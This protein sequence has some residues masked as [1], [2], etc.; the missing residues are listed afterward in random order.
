M[1]TRRSAFKAAAGIAAATA[2]G[3]PHGALAADKV[4]DVG[5]D[6]SFTGADAES[7]QRVAN[8]AIMAFDDANKNHEVPGYTFNLIKFDDGTATAG[9]YDP[10]QAATNARKMVSD[11]NMVAAVG[12]QMSGAGKAMAPILSAGDLA[13]ITPSSTNPDITDPKFAAQ[14]RPA[15]KPIYFRTVAT[16]AY[17][18][19]NMANYM[20]ETLHVKTVYILDDSGAYGVGLADAFQAQATKI[21]L[22]VLGRDRLDPKAADYSAVLTKIKSLNPDALYFGGV[23]QAGVKLAKQSYDIIPKVIK[24]GGDGMQSADLLSGAGFPAVEGWYATIAAPHVS[25]DPQLAD[26]S[27]RYFARFKMQPDDYTITNYDGA[28]AIINAVKAVIKAGKPV[29]RSNVRDAL[30]NV[31]FTSLQGPIAFDANGDLKNKVISVFQ[32]RKDASKP[33]N[34]PNAQYKYIGVAPQ[35]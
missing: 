16:D 11:T 13:I 29:N 15:G 1:I 6:F 30:Q 32:I 17:Q 27:K 28:W 21:G 18:G 4:I 10:A 34:D 8:G 12:P 26:F 14:Y 9:Q 5:G 25:D 20:K 31:S 33:L 7:A 23:G 22:K 3:A 35:A 19:P 24:A 2:L